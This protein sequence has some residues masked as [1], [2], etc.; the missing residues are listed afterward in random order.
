MTKPQPPFY[1]KLPE[2]SMVVWVYTQGEREGEREER[3]GGGREGEREREGER[4]LLCW[5]HKSLARP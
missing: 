2:Q 4:N 3:R 5:F 1:S